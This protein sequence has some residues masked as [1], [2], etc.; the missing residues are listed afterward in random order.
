MDLADSLKPC[1]FC[2]GTPLLLMSGHGAEIQCSECG[3][4][5]VF[6]KERLEYCSGLGESSEE[7][8]RKTMRAWNRRAWMRAAP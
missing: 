8:E 5:T 1:P 6:S 3:A 7:H 4:I 2:G